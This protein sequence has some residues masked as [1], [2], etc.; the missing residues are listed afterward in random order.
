MNKAIPNP[1]LFLF[2]SRDPDIINTK[3]KNP[4]TTGR[5]CENIVV[6]VIGIL[7]HY[8]NLHFFVI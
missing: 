1:N 6:P 4:Q 5:M 2:S 3:A 7:N 8:Y